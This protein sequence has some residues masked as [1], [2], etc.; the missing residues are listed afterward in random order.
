MILICSRFVSYFQIFFL[1]TT[2]LILSF[3][4]LF[5][6]SSLSY[7]FFSLP[8]LLEEFDS[9]LFPLATMGLCF[10]TTCSSPTPFHINLPM[11]M[12]VSLVESLP[13]LWAY[14]KIKINKLHVHIEI[15]IENVSA[16]FIQRA[17][18][19][20]KHRKKG[21]R[22]LDLY[23]WTARRSWSP[24]FSS[25]EGTLFFSQCFAKFECTDSNAPSPV[26]F[27]SQNSLT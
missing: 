5:T 12:H 4:L 7:F 16:Y 26:C 23:S 13:C 1:L 22:W 21:Q 2:F 6:S 25:D 24:S 8:F 19:I 11:Y 9:R 20:K 27:E 3:S 14:C 10:R 15:H 17:S 18:L